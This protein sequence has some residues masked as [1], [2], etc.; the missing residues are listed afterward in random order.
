M[1]GG[2]EKTSVQVKKEGSIKQENEDVSILLGPNFSVE[3]MGQKYGS[4]WHSKLALNRISDSSLQQQ[5]LKSRPFSKTTL[6]VGHDGTQVSLNKYCLFFNDCYIL[7]TGGSPFYDIFMYLLQNLDNEF[8]EGQILQIMDSQKRNFDS[9]FAF[10]AETYCSNILG[11]FNK[12]KK[13]GRPKIEK[14]MYPAVTLEIPSF[15]DVKNVLFAI[16]GN[17]HLFVKKF[18]SVPSKSFISPS[19]KIVGLDSGIHF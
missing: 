15:A 14:K 18:S 9:F 13:G 17:S 10:V 19:K 2:S 7:G 12:M 5:F 16:P 1:D 3:S 6:S 11:L 8:Q 4:G